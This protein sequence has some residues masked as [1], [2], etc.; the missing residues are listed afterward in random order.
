MRTAIVNIKDLKSNW[1]AE[2]YCDP[3]PEDLIKAKESG[4]ECGSRA[5]TLGPQEYYNHGN[6]K[7]KETFVNAYYAG[8][9]AR[10]KYLGD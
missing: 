8:L 10:E 9:K 7:V 6:R 4:W 2:T 3:T 5:S 1:C